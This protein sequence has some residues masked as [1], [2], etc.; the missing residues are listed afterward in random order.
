MAY[1]SVL[2]HGCSHMLFFVAFSSVATLVVL[3]MVIAIISDAYSEVD[4]EMQ[5]HAEELRAAGVNP[6]VRESPLLESSNCLPLRQIVSKTPDA[7]LSRNL[8]ESPRG[9]RAFLG[10]PEL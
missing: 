4:S 9:A 2:T 3:N 10:G 6:G 5:R 1:I 7:I 8:A